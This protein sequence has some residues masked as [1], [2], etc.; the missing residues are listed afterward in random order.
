MSFTR[1]DLAPEASPAAERSY[2]D[3]RASLKSNRDVQSESD[4]GMFSD[5]DGRSHALSLA[6]TT[7]GG[8]GRWWDEPR[9]PSTKE[10][11]RR[12]SPTVEPRGGP[13]SPTPTNSWVKAVV[14]DLEHPTEVAHQHLEAGR[15]EQATEATPLQQQLLDAVQRCDDVADA[16]A[17]VRLLNRAQLHELRT[18]FMLYSSRGQQDSAPAHLVSGLDSE[19]GPASPLPPPP[20]RP[21]HALFPT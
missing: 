9:T 20:R 1:A 6:S 10:L 2:P 13:S 15:L 4:S 8:G 21:S 16:T 7:L 5:D 14:Y 17:G 12:L 11:A 18:I 3:G 19:Q